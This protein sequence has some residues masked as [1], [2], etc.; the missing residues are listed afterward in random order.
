MEHK[1]TEL[2]QLINKSIKNQRHKEFVFKW[3]NISII[4]YLNQPSPKI[5]MSVFLLVKLQKDLSMEKDEATVLQK[6]KTWNDFVKKLKN[7]KDDNKKILG[8]SEW[9][10][11]APEYNNYEEFCT[12][13]FFGVS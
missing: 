7:T 12:E 6:L 13:F 3:V 4:P 10:M 9:S 11:I 8:Y 5:K 1:I 2:K